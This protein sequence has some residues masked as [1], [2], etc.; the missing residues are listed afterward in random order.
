MVNVR[1]VQF[2]RAKVTDLK[3]KLKSKKLPEWAHEAQ[4]KGDD[5]YIGSLRVVAKEDIDDYLRQ[6]V[7]S[8]SEAPVPFSRDTGYDFIQKHTLGIS[9]RK[10]FS[11]LKAQELHQ[12]Q[13]AR[14]AVPVRAG[15]RVTRRGL[16]QFDL[17][18][19]KPRDLKM[20]G[21]TL[22]T[23]Y[24]TMVDLLTGYFVVRETKQKNAK[25]VAKTLGP[26]LDEMEAAL[27]RPVHTIQSDHGSEFKA[28]T[29]ALM[30]KR[31]I[32]WQGVRLGARI[33]QM[34]AYFQKRL[35]SLINQR[36]G[37]KLDKYLQEAATILNETKSRITRFSPK[38]AVQQTDTTLAKAFNAPGKRAQARKSSKDI[39]IVV[40]D[41]VRVL[42]KPR[43]G[44]KL[45]FKSY[46][47]KHYS[48]PA[49]VTS[50]RGRGFRVNGASY[51]RDR[52][53]KV[54]AIDKKSAALL[55][56]RAP[57]KPTKQEAAKHRTKRAQKMAELKQEARVNPRRS[58]RA[59]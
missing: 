21:R 56:A 23:Y 30:K 47:A 11:W 33:E 5:L 6:R 8:K 10:W 42:L 2:T 7:Y 39:P 18:E 53:L 50:K 17:V 35:Y 19:A 27:G 12:K 28:E 32:R 51:P 46:R 14:P 55:A 1:R 22:P 38:D 3:S 57:K 54:P 4:V 58:K 59:R 26:M 40:G 31:N 45:E 34:N 52:L 13:T 25:L 20:L 48:E 43:K 37:G 9:R 41:T 24:F 15:Q 49:K 29:L 44:N 36:R 16:L